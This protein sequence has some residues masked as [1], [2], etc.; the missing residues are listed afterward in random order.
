MPNNGTLRLPLVPIGLHS[1]LPLTDDDSPTDFPSD[2]TP[3]VATTSDL[4]ASATSVVNTPT[5]QSEGNAKENDAEENGSFWDYLKAKLDA[6]KS[7]AVSV[8]SSTTT[9]T[10]TTKTEESTSSNEPQ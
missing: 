8:F 3:T 7:W 4:A 10:T 6:A 2:P 1:D 9:V 5:S